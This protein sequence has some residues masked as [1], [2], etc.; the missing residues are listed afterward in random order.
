M[1]WEPRPGARFRQERGRARHD[2]ARASDESA[3][4]QDTAW[5]ALPTTA[6][7]RKT[8]R[9][10]ARFRRE[11]ES[12]RPTRLCARAARREVRE[13]PAR[14]L[15]YVELVAA[16]QLRD[17]T[18]RERSPHAARGRTT[19]S[20]DGGGAPEAEAEEAIARRGSARIGGGG[21]GRRSTA[22]AAAARARDG[23]GARFCPLSRELARHRERCRSDDASPALLRP[24]AVVVRRAHRDGTDVASRGRAREPLAL[25]HASRDA[26][27][28]QHPH[29][30][31]TAATVRATRARE[32][33]SLSRR[34]LPSTR[35]Y[36]PRTPHS[37]RAAG[38]RRGVT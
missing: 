12:R 16:Q 10:G 28:W 2:A 7:T 8:T 13:R 14:L 21:R 30:H 9:R 37:R 35:R 3:D 5:H 15:A 27:R 20:N 4:V 38:A 19:R 23:R 1:A 22:A 34:A 29:L 17:A 32:S 26:T 36:P 31:T 25:I 24:L 11:R 33:P 18:T 6:L